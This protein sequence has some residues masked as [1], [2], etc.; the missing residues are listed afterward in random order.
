MKENIQDA[1]NSFT[2]YLE[3]G[4]LIPLLILVSA[5]HYVYVLQDYEH[6]L[7]AGAIGLLI[8]LGHYRSIRIAARYTGDKG[9]EKIARWAVVTVLTVI[10]LYYHRLFYDDWLLAAPIPILIGA[11]AYF[12][13]KRTNTERRTSE[14]AVAQPRT[15]QKRAPATTRSNGHK[16][17]LSDFERAIIAGKVDPTAMTGIEIGQWANVSAA[18]GRRWKREVL[19][20]T[21]TGERR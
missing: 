8:D 4:D 14:R 3:S 1:W 16:K 10:A 19:Y 15:E 20:K 18:T 12:E 21:E 17:T 9:K 11:L 5:G 6:W 13:R 7:T 2:R